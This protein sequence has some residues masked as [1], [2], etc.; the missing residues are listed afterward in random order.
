MALRY[1][2]LELST[3]VKPWLLRHLLAATGGPVTYLDPDIKIYG[4][5]QPAR[6]SW[7]PSTASS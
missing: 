4:S 5:L 3:A 1:S 7:R 2:V 6:A